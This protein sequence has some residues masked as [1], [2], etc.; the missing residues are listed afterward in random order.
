[1]N[2]IIFTLFIWVTSFLPRHTYDV[3]LWSFEYQYKKH[4]IVIEK[5]YE[6]CLEGADDEYIADANGTLISFVADDLLPGDEATIYY[7]HGE[8]ISVLYG[9]R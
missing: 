3:G 6:G 8:I 5:T 7:L 1:M 4:A 2:K 9:W